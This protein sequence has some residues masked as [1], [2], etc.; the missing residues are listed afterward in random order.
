MKKL[1]ALALALTLVCL[2]FA[3][4]GNDTPAPFNTDP[5]EETSQPA[6]DAGEPSSTLPDDEDETDATDNDS[7]SQ[8]SYEEIASALSAANLLGNWS[9][10]YSDLTDEQ[11]EALEDA[12]DLDE[13]DL[14][15][16]ADLMDGDGVIDYTDED[17]NAFSLGGEWPDN[18]FT[19]KI[20]KP[21]GEYTV[22]G[23]STEGDSLTITMGG[24]TVE[25][26]A[27]YAE[28]IKSAGFT[29]DPEEFNYLGMYSYSADNGEYEVT[30]T[31]S[32]SMTIL[33]LERI[34]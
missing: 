24:M 1:L 17:G 13:D 27:E 5:P 9:G 15:L 11:L 29:R 26:C 23:T 8:P 16:W 10:D 4:C 19:R 14:A 2:L 34:D 7:P 33:E 30:L 22:L 20:P 3:S 18:E 12:Y 32:I 21:D 31:F 28:K 6:P 25:D